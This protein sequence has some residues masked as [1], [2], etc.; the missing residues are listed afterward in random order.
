MQGLRKD[1]RERRY[2]RFGQLLVEQQPHD[3]RSRHAEGTTLTLGG[4]RE[5]GPDVLGAQL[6]E[7][8]QQLSL[9]HA[10]SQVPE[11]IANG[12]ARAP[13]TGLAESDLGICDDAIQRAH[14][15]SLRQAAVSAASAMLCSSLRLTAQRAGSAAAHIAV[16]CNRL[17]A[18][19]G[20]KRLEYIP[21]SRW[22][23][24]RSS[25]GHLHHESTKGSR[26]FRLPAEIEDR[27]GC[28]FVGQGVSVGDT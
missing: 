2:E 7:F 3:L 16:R 18:S 8:A 14:T 20:I 17:L 27:V 22:P 21:H 4:I 12:D 13:D 25:V 15:L 23:V 19:V 1:I 10:A 24:L 9:G 28:G 6:R 5:A 11:D 26:N